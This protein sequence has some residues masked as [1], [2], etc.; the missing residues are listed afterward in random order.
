M[1]RSGNKDSARNICLYTKIQKGGLRNKVV[2]MS[3]R[4]LL[5]HISPG[6]RSKQKVQNPGRKGPCFSGEEALT[7]TNQPTLPT[8]P[9]KKTK[10]ELLTHA[11]L[12]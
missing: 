7:R 4:A 2:E 6:D 9:P 12:A 1:A 10:K 8:R 3:L 5:F 11:F